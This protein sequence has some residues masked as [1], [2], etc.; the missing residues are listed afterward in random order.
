M[1]P[2]AAGDGRPAAA[3]DLVSAV[4]QAG[5]VSVAVDPRGFRS[6]SMNDVLRAAGDS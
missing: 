2:R 1:L 5:F 3:R 4:G 6:G